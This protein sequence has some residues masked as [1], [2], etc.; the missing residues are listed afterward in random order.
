MKIFKIGEQE[1]HCHDDTVNGL[2]DLCDGVLDK[3]QLVYAIQQLQKQL[4]ENT[5]I[6]SIDTFSLILH[7]CKEQGVDEAIVI[8]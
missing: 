2:A 8:G 6:H 4:T 1:Y 7:Y 5:Y 3:D